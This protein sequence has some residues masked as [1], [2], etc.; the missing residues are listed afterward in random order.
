MEEIKQAIIAEVT[1]MAING[2]EYEEEVE[3]EATAETTEETVEFYGQTVNAAYAKEMKVFRE[4]LLDAVV[5]MTKS[6]FKT[7]VSFSET[8]FLK[9]AYGVDLAEGAEAPKALDVKTV[10][11]GE[12]APETINDESSYAASVYML[13]AAPAPNKDLTRDIT[14]ATFTTEADAKEFI[15]FLKGK[16]ETVTAEDFK[17]YAEEKDYHYVDV[18]SYIVDHTG[19]M[20]KAY[21]ADF[22]THMNYEGIDAWMQVLKLYAKTQSLEEN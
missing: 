6:Y 7:D 20:A 11:S 1:D 21:C 18:A 12:K 4:D 2:K 17:A 22:S 15:E 13:V 16:G 9:W 14:F 19:G 5:S 3:G 10:E 8:E